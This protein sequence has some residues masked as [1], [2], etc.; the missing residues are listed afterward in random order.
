MLIGLN[1]ENRDMRLNVL[2][3]PWSEMG[4]FYS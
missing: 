4:T 1:V 2:D 3:T